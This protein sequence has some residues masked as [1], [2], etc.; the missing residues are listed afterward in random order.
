MILEV[1]KAEYVAEYKIKVWFNNGETKI[2]D[3][4]STIWNDRRKIFEPLRNIEFFKS[5]NLQLDT[6]CWQNGLDLAPEFL[7]ELDRTPEYSLI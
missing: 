3:L 1:I 7:Y 2:T 5:F 4:K 6:V